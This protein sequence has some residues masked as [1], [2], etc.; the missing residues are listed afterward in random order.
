MATRKNTS[1][2]AHREK[3]LLGAIVGRLPKSITPD[4]LTIIGLFGA[5]IAAAGFLLC[6]WSSGFLFF[7]ILGLLLNWFGD[8]LDGTLAR[9]RGIERPRHG[10][11]IDHSSDLIALSAIIMGLGSSPYFTLSS[12]LFVLSLYLLISSYT[13]IKVATTGIHHMSYG[14]LGATEFRILIAAWA[15]FAEIA[16][17]SFVLGR[18]YGYAGLDVVIGALSACTYVF[19]IYMVRNDITLAASEEE[20]GTTLA[21]RFQRHP[22]NRPSEL[23]KTDSGGGKP[24]EPVEF[25]SAQ[26]II[27]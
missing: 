15:I 27:H 9:Y 2:L 11:F 26:Q 1:F 13:Y 17:P 4:Q 19:F 12:A 8:S 5:V 21:H 18:I 24:R 20:E 22:Q 7:V 6:N 16:G 25:E 10:F 14:G 23:G 3:I